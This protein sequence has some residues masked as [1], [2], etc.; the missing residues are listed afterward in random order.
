[1][2]G[3]PRV[4]EVFME[5]VTSEFLDLGRMYWLSIS[6]S[7]IHLLECTDYGIVLSKATT[8]DFSA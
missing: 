8:G 3:W 4:V 1:M 7:T 5:E 6:P 2:A